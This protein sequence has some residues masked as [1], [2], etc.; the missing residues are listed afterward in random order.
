MA[1][2]GPPPEVRVRREG[3]GRPV[4]IIRNSWWRRSAASGALL[5]AA[6][7][8]ALPLQASSV[9]ASERGAAPLPGRLAVGLARPATAQVGISITILDGVFCTSGS[10]CWAVGQRQS[11]PAVLNQVLH[12]NGKSW[13]NTT[14]PN[15]AG[16]SANSLNELFA[17]RC[18]SA[19]NCWAVGE[20][21]KNGGLTTLNQALHWNGRKW[22][23]VHTPDPAGT[24]ANDN[25]E[26]FD[27]TCTSSAS[28]WSVGDF[29]TPFSSTGH[30]KLLNQV[31]HWNGNR[32]SRVR[33]TN[34][35]GTSMNHLNSLFSV[36]CGSATNCN[37]AGDEGTTRASTFKVYNEIFHWNGKRWSQVR[38]P[39][40]GPSGSGRYSQ[41]DALACGSATYCW[42][43]GSYGSNSPALTSQNEI[44]HWN[45]KKWTRS[46]VPNP[47]GD[48][49]QLIGATC[50]STR[51][52]W[53]LGSQVN[54]ADGTVNEAL[55]WNG[56]HWSL[57]S[58]P[59]PGGTSMGDMNV[60]LSAR[61]PSARS[62]WAVGYKLAA[63]NTYRDEVLHW[64]GKKWAVRST[65]G[66]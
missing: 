26:L 62:C 28:C 22:A 43:A 2:D 25:N 42:G 37:A 41:I 64:N 8:L 15:P 3:W 56:K 57:V 39:Q 58:T 29:G 31:L 19:R 54:S 35:G 18:L 44:L 5:V 16:K 27:V 34:P 13:R 66:S 9:Q 23:L 63:A 33:T 60:L 12:W 36:R 48:D 11:G 51:N 52:C 30:Q 49:N 40:P 17:V 4:R 20:D 38:T 1:R 47:A 6:S 65:P 50:S 7:F 10:N 59:N 14:V 61:C 21:T 53:A 24:K 55:H 32:W 45:G 46:T